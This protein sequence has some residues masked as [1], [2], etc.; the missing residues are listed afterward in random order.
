MY[1][2]TCQKKKRKQICMRMHKD[3][4]PTQV[5]RQKTKQIKACRNLA[6]AVCLIK[7]KGKL[8]HEY[9]ISYRRGN[10]LIEGKTSP[11]NRSLILLIFLIPHK[12]EIESF[13]L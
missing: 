10:Y 3:N 11:I 7:E 5:K 12:L 1:L 8:A 6:L 4:R 13:S 2:D 9:V